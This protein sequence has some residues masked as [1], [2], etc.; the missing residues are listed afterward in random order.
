M[1]DWLTR[2]R[3]RFMILWKHSR[4]LLYKGSFMENAMS[5]IQR[6]DQNRYFSSKENICEI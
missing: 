5:L 3:L 2:E 1:V 6:K 4:V